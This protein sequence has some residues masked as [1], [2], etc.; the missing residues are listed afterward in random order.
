MILS[1]IMTM[2]R[3]AHNH[4]I[5][6]RHSMTGMFLELMKTNRINILNNNVCFNEN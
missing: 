3:R 2:L 6:N 4:K 5:I 1:K